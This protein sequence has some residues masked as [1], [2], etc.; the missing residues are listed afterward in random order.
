M[1]VLLN[2]IKN[3]DMKPLRMMV[4]LILIFIICLRCSEGEDMTSLIGIPDKPSSQTVIINDSFENKKV[5]VV[6]NQSENFIVSFINKLNGMELEFVATEEDLPIIMRDNLGNEWD[7]FGEAVS[8]P[9]I[10]QKLKSTFSM[11]GYWFSIATFYPGTIIYPDNDAGKFE[12]KI[13]V[14]TQGWTVPK[15]RV[16]S[17][18]PGIDGIPS[19][20]MP[21]F[22]NSGNNLNQ[23]IV[24]IKLGDENRAY[25]HNILDWHEIVNDRIGDTYFAVIYCPL[26]GTATCW[27]RQVVR[28]IGSFGVSGLLYESN[29]VPYDRNTGSRWSQI[30]NEAIVGSLIREKPIHYQ[31]VETTLG[32][33]LEM[34]PDSKVLTED[35][36]F[37]RSYGNY[38]YGGYK[39][40]GSLLF[41]VQFKDERLHLKER[42]HTIIINNKAKVYRFISFQ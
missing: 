34:Y 19:V 32:S 35:T 28:G 23:L 31:V 3:R 16:V 39:T 13:V 25:P 22:S 15:E 21:R 9:D 36:G 6:G 17:G 2:S 7:I 5:V 42:V 29:I 27:D 30:K 24:G 18:G 12:G 40:N 20:D 8:G 41:N 4:T 38:P 33:W 11:I 10:G 1:K 14:G 37:N 26:T